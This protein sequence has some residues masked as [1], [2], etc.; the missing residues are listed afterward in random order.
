[1][2]IKEDI[3]DMGVIVRIK[4]LNENAIIPS[5]A[6]EDS[7]G[8]DIYACL[9]DDG[10]VKIEPGKAFRVP[11]GVA[12]EIPRGTFGGLFARS[13]ISTKRGLR[14]ANCVGVVDPDYRG[15][16][17][18]PLYND[19]NVIRTIK[20]GDRIAQLLLIPAFEIDFEEVGE[21]SETDR[22]LGGFGSTGL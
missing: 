17:Q 1:M 8:Y 9:P 10:E 6:S 11:T 7:A 19:S 3:G 13:G 2:I 22:S 5:R 16:V 4:R 18:V 14:P 21:L 15:E 12:M 20:N